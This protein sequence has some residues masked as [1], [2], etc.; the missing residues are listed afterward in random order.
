MSERKTDWLP[1]LL[2]EGTPEGQVRAVTCDDALI[3]VGAGA[4]T[5]K[6]WVLSTRYARLLFSD[7]DCLPQNILTLTFTEAAAREM[8]ERIRKRAFALMPLL[9]PE[10]FSREERQA[11]EE[12]FDETWIST[13]HSFAARLIRESGLALDVD[14]RSSVISDPQKE[15]FRE[16]LKQAL[17]ALDL[18]TFVASCGSRNLLDAAERL[19]SDPILIAALEKWQP[20]TLCNLA[21]NVTELHS[22]LGHSWQTLTEWAKGAEREDDPRAKSMSNALRDLL[23]PR[24]DEAWQL[25]R[26]VFGEFGGDILDARDAVLRKATGKGK[27]PVLALAMLLEKWGK[28]LRLDENA[29]GDDPTAIER[30][31]LFYTDLCE[32][33]SGGRSTLFGAIGERLGQSITSWKNAQKKWRELSKISPEAPLPEAERR[34]RAVL[35]RLSA[36]AWESWDGM[37]RRRS[38]LSFTDMIRFAASSI[39]AD[40]RLKGFKHILIDEFQDTDPL[41]NSLI[42]DLQ[43]KE[44]AKL[45]V[46]GDPKQAIYRFRHAD[47]TLFADTVLQSRSSGSD[48]TLNVS[49]R[50]RSSLLRPINS[51]FAHIWEKGLGA[52]ER[53]SRLKFEPLDPPSAPHP[54][55]DLSTVTPFTLLLAVR[56]GRSSRETRKRLARNLARIFTRWIEEGRTVWDGRNEVLRP[57]SWKDFAILTPTRG[58]YETLE[59]MFTKENIPVVF[60]SNS[61]YFSRGEIT[62]VVNTMR[63]AAFPSDETAFAGWLSSPFSGVSRSDATTCLN[64]HATTA[65][66]GEISLLDVVQERFPEA[67]ERLEHLR[68]LGN[69]RGPSALLSSLLENRNWLAAFRRDQRLRVVSNVT[70]AISM[71]AGYES[72]VSPSLAGCTQWLDTA[73]RNAQTSEEAPW[74]DPDADA[75]HV[76]TIHS[77]KGL[78]FP[79]VAVMAMDRGVGGKGNSATLAPSKTMGVVL[80]A[81]PDMMRNTDGMEAEEELPRSLKQERALSAQSELEESTRLFYVATTRA[82]DAL[83]LCGA[84]SENKDGERSVKQDTWLEHTLDWLGREQGCDWQDLEGPPL[85]WAEDEEEGETGKT[86]SSGVTIRTFEKVEQNVPSPRLTLPDSEEISLSSLSATSYALF[87]WCPFAW[88]RRHR[89]GLD[90]RWE[91]PDEPG[92]VPGGSRL[93]TLAHWILA[94]WD[95]TPKGLEKWLDNSAAPLRLPADLRDTWRNA[96]NREALRSWLMDLTRSEEGRLIAEA[97]RSGS[98]RREAPFCVSIG[99]DAGHLYLVGAIDALWRD[100]RNQWFVR[101]YKITLSDNAPAELY[102]AQLGFYALVVKLLA[103]KQGL[104]FEGV[105]VGLVFLREGGR[106]GDARRFSK[107]D[108]WATMEEH[109]RLA[110]Q[111]TVRGDWIPRREHCRFCPWKKGCGKTKK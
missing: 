2:P 85:V 96:R 6:T 24:W 105:D 49:F 26:S 13:I 19:E 95:L 32:N 102:R 25:W 107:N 108:D 70:K 5:G 88:R 53:M 79:V 10:N 23:Q 41:Q 83:I 60:E 44:G 8:Q 109:I 51:L 43:T 66:M 71:A 48:I 30:R 58:E 57:V 98:L 76:L 86:R 45:F 67:V 94:E 91:A 12:G 65:R 3:T 78:E 61:S 69:L 21:V 16:N 18:R 1:L 104:P 15:K 74:M 90:L 37:K 29:S 106:S 22:S 11:L 38:L 7:S 77:S 28:D 89:Q 110:A 42:R 52:G 50:T 68:R 46:V 101:D 35:L 14:P 34:L 20:D 111:T 99:G 75:V 72:G 97:A 81:I 40:E 9:S 31:R 63:A 4:G 103:K 92:D 73:L 27:S 17:D 64:L 84:V 56:Q 100:S 47:L 33:L 55:R 87:E 82:R 39:G 93:G 59:D 80:S 54:N 36:L 62:D